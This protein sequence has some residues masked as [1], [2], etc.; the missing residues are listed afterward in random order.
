MDINVVRNELATG[1]GLSVRSLIWANQNGTRPKGTH[2]TLYPLSVDED[3]RPED[4]ITVK[5]QDDEIH[6]NYV[7]SFDVQV[8]DKEYNNAIKRLRNMVNYLNTPPVVA[9]MASSGFVFIDSGSIVDLVAL[10]DG[11]SFESRA[12]VTLRFR[13]TDI[14]P[15]KQEFIETAEIQNIKED[16]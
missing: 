10:L 12:S 9:N 13:T 3:T 11:S 15:Y 5:G 14:T 8:Y 2:A 6:I 1:L 4:V 7:N 16:N